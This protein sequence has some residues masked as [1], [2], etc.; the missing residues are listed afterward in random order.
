MCFSTIIIVSNVIFYTIY[1]YIF[2]K[3][4]FTCGFEALHIEKR[5]VYRWRLYVLSSKSSFVQTNC[6]Q[7]P[8]EGILGKTT[9]IFEA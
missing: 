2:I 1:N 7:N 9:D 6:I 5:V 3:Q 8:A 4:S